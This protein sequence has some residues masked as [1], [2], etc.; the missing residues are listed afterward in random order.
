M[1]FGIRHA[2]STVRRYMVKRCPGRGDSQAW[3]SFLKDQAKAIWCC[4]FFVQYTVGFRVLYIFVIMGLPSRKVI[5]L[6]VTGHPTLEWTKQQ[7]RNACFEEEPKFLLYD[8][9]GELGRPFRVKMAEEGKTRLTSKSLPSRLTSRVP[10]FRP[11]PLSHSCIEVRPFAASARVTILPASRSHNTE[12]ATA[13]QRSQ[14][15]KLRLTVENA[16]CRSGM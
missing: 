10:L 12:L 9:D 8:N 2:C 7:M 15:M 1:K 6:H 4:D 5:H 11:W 13:A 3:R 16:C 14:S